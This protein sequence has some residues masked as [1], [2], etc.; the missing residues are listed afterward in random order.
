MIDEI[1][2]PEPDEY[3]DAELSYRRG[4]QQG[5]DFVLSQQVAG[6]SPEEILHAVYRAMHQWRIDG[7][8]ELAETGKVRRPCWLTTSA[9]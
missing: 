9:D 5:A 2:P 3:S 4:L 8:I 6:V 1:N 7:M